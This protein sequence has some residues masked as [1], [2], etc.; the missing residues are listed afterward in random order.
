MNTKMPLRLAMWPL[1][2]P[3][4]IILGGCNQ[5]VSK[6]RAPLPKAETDLT[7]PCR[8]PG[9]TGDKGRDALRHRAALAKCESKRAGWQ[10]FYD[11]VT[12]EF[13]N[14]DERVQ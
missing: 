6:G 5:Y 11:D 10:S 13:G 2:L 14:P 1:V 9:F 8:D 7:I 4:L 12:A 3:I